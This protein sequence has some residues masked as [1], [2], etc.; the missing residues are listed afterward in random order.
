MTRSGSEDRSGFHGSIEKEEPL[1][2][3]KIMNKNATP[4]PKRKGNATPHLS[5]NSDQI[6]AFGMVVPMPN[7]LS[8]EIC[9]E[10]VAALNKMLAD[11]ITLRDLYKKHH[12]QVAGANFYS[13]LSLSFDVACRRAKRIR[14]TH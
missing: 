9:T 6:Q 8:K 7:G 2:K 4:E 11:T 3:P 5:E 14:S 1:G 10:S 12:W 13:L